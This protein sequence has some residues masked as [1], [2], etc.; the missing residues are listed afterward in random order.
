MLVTRGVCPQPFDSAVAIFDGALVAAQ[1]A[2]YVAYSHI[3]SSLVGFFLLIGV[4]RTGSLSLFT[5]WLCIKVGFLGRGVFTFYK[6]FLSKSDP[7]AL[8]KPKVVQPAEGAV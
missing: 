1:R 8:D 2:N 5:A 4:L 3:A 6:L 7:Y